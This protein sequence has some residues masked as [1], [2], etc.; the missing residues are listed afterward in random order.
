MGDQANVNRVCFFESVYTSTVDIDRQSIC[1]LCESILTVDIHYFFSSMDRIDRGYG[2]Y[3]PVGGL[4]VNVDI[5]C[6]FT[7]R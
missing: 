2:P 4:T 3:F 1:L 7:S 5:D 6:I